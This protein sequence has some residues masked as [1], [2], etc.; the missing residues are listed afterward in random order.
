MEVGILYD[1]GTGSEKCHHLFKSINAPFKC[2]AYEINKGKFPTSTKSCD[3]YIVAG[4]IKAV[5]DSNPWI[6]EL[7]RFIKRVDREER[8]LIGIC[9]GHQAIAQALGG[10]ASKSEKG[11]GLGLKEFKIRRHK[12]WMEPVLDNCNLYFVHQDQVMR[13]PSEA[14]LLGTSDFCVNN[15]YCIGNR[16]LGIQGHPEYSYGNLIKIMELLKD[17]VPVEVYENGLNSVDKGEPDSL[18][19]AKWIVNFIIAA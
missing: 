6:S 10:Y 11:W 7:S 1:S 3:A 12:S 13:L 2:R 16:V 4:S 18:T 9:F 17:Q 19:I 15:I 14:E 5:Y 8:K